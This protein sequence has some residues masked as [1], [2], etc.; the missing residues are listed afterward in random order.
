MPEAK[1]FSVTCSPFRRPSLEYSPT[2]AKAAC[3]YPNS[4]RAMR[5]ARAR[6]FDNAVM[7]D[8]LSNVSELA[9][10]NIWY[11]RDGEVY[12][13]VPNGTFLNGITRQRIIN[14]LT[15]DGIKVHER[16]LKWQDF[17]EA[18]E[19]FSTGNWAKVAPITRVEDRDLQPGPMYS[20]DANCTGLTRTQRQATAIDSYSLSC[21]NFVLKTAPAFSAG[22]GFSF[23]N[24]STVW[25]LRP[26]GPAEKACRFSIFEACKHRCL[27]KGRCLVGA[28]DLFF[29]RVR[30]LR[31]QPEAQVHR[32]HQSGL[33]VLVIKAQ[34]G[35]ERRDHVAD[36]V[37]GANHAKA[38]RAATSDPSPGRTRSPIVQRL[39]NVA[40]PK[41]RAHHGSVRSSGPRGQGRG[42]CPRSP[43]QVAT[44]PA[45]RAGG[46]TACVAMR[47]L[48]VFLCA[49]D[50][51]ACST[52]SCRWQSTRWSLTMPTACMKA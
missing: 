9:T 23:F 5:E 19:V 31:R 34:S 20:R 41:R 44:A 33:E 17:S 38:P 39:Q 47:A 25:L 37:L 52:A 36:H 6:G 46:L 8:P 4:A 28:L 51:L 32:F 42:Q 26:A 3:H 22:R 13:P 14:L 30:Q 15:E 45:D 35:L 1:G 21:A 2:D 49:P 24:S 43:H 27:E 48:P 11:A 29:D 40:R 50:F 18:D 12:T 7:L 10:A 16:S